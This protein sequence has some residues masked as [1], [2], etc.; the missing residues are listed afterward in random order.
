MGN[1]L[2]IFTFCFALT[3]LVMGNVSA[4]IAK[5]KRT[6][7]RSTSDEKKSFEGPCFDP[8]KGNTCTLP[9]PQP[10]EDSDEGELNESI[11]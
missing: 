5:E 4:S 8:K 1:K 6:D 2:I 10:K 11:F 9:A 7:S 3:N